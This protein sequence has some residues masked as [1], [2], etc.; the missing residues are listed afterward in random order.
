VKN[1]IVKKQSRVKRSKAPKKP[2][3]RLAKAIRDKAK[4][5]RKKLKI[6][7]PVL[8]HGTVRETP[9]DPRFVNVD[10]GFGIGRLLVDRDQVEA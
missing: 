3:P 7:M 10:F 8:V 1:Q 6:G 4:E 2:S 5:I 9:D